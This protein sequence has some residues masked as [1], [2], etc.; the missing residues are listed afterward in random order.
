MPE[1]END[2]AH[3]TLEETHPTR[4]AFY[5]VILVDVVPAKRMS[6]VDALMKISLYRGK[7]TLQEALLLT[8][9]LPSILVRGVTLKQAVALEL[10]FE[11]YG[12]TVDIQASSRSRQLPSESG[13]T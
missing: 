11:V 12:G 6:V 3:R 13:N 2:A 10:V 5:D 4:E 7:I 8:F 9:R 1:Y